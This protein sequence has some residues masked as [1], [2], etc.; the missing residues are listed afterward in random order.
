MNIK[1]NSNV[2]ETKLKACTS[3]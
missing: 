1:T 2:Y 3:V